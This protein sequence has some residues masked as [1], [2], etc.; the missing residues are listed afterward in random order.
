MARVYVFSDE[1]GNFDFSLNLGATRWS[2]LGSVTIH[3]PSIGDRL[4]ALR[5]ELAWQGVALDS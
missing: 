4:I 2:I 3:D 5:R 1:A